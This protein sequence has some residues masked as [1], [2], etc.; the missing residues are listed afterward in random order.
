MKKLLLFFILIGFISVNAQL[1]C[2]DSNAN[3]FNVLA[4]QNNGSCTYSPSFQV[5]TE[6]GSLFP[7]APESSGIIYDDGFIYTHNDSG[8]P[9]KFYK[10][11]A[12]NGD[13]IQTINITN[14]T[15]DDW[16]EI[17]SDND[18]IYIA[19]TGNN[20]GIR[21]NLRVLKIS[22]SQFINDASTNVNV[23]AE[24]INFSYA[25]QT[26][27]PTNQLNNFDCE[28]MISLGN[29]LY[30]FTKNRGNGQTKIYKLSKI[31][32]TY[33]LSI[34]STYN[35]GG[36]L[37]GATINSTNNE[38][39]LIGYMPPNAINS[40]IYYLNDFTSDQFF[41]GNVRR[42]EIGTP[43]NAWQTEGICFKNA[44]ELFLS[45]EITNFS[46]AKLF[47]TNKSSI[48]LGNNPFLLNNDNLK[49][50][51]NPSNDNF[52]F[53]NNEIM[54]SIDILTFDGKTIFKK[55]IDCKEF[56][57]SKKDFTESSGSY[58]IKIK[59]EKEIV[60]RKIIVK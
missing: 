23:T 46:N 13:L 11:N 7:A 15:N 37:T 55:D 60:I 43:S 51:P 28:S 21:T 20:L 10:I 39:A 4:T 33:S 57:L 14:F 35:V 6:I 27:F 12:S 54:N 34:H 42:V 38:I 36:L 52:N 45:C 49:I 5:A 25:D 40:F 17:S 30:L 31:P 47:L 29:Y 26:S 44:N 2:T 9:S 3:N 41:S 1:G 32:D 22:K 59:T 8:N 48:S 16:E 53:I 56:K 50:Y 19:D 58:L 18:F 24:A